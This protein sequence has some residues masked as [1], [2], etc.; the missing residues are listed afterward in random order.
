MT[1]PEP[2]AYIVVN[3][4]LVPAGETHVSALDRGFTLGD[5]LFETMRARAERVLRLNE[6]LARLRAGAAMLDLALLPDD[7]LRAAIAKA[8]RAHA[9]PDGVARLTVTRGV[10]P[11]RGLEISATLEPTIVVRVTPF[12]APQT[13]VYQHGISA[14]VSSIRRNDTSPLSHVKSLNYGDNILARREARRRGADDALLLNTKG[15]V[16]CA[17]AANLLMVSDGTLY[18]PPVES[19]A[20]PG[21]TRGAVL[22]AAATLGIPA[23]IEP[24]TLERL[25]AAHEAFLTNTVMG[26]LP[27]TRL[28]GRPIGDGV[29]G[30]MTGTLAAAYA[31]RVEQL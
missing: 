3:G 17:T 5:G 25:A 30:A 4:R 10:D 29:P 21:V 23:S 24:L 26:V 16:A 2:T 9:Y 18:T 12:V 13:K 19:G 1:P 14:V 15:E 22:E 8:L 27:L 7:A 31:R 20:L 28:E 6:H 11:G